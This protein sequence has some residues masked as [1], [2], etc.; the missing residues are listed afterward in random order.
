MDSAMSHKRTLLIAIALGFAGGFF[1]V[2]VANGGTFGTAAPA[3]E[4]SYS[5]AG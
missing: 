3:P 2:S 4:S 5:A 1:F